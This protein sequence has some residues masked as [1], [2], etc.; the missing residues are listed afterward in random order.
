MHY[1]ILS[2]AFA[3][4]SGL[5]V[6]TAH[7]VRERRRQ[8]E[9]LKALVSAEEPRAIGQAQRD[10]LS[11]FFIT[12]LPRITQ[13]LVPRQEGDSRTQTP[14]RGL[15]VQ[16]G[17]YQKEHE[18]IFIG[19][20]YVVTCLP[21]VGFVAGWLSHLWDMDQNWIIVTGLFMFAAWNLPMAWLNRRKRARQ[22]VL[23]GALPDALD[24]IMICLEGGLSLP[25]ALCRIASELHTV[26]PELALEMTIV[27][28]YIQ[29]G[30]SAGEAL[31]LFADRCDLDEARSLSSAVLQS[32]RF[33]ASLVSSLRI[34]SDMLRMRR[35]QMAEEKAH[36]AS[37]QVLFPTLLL[38]FPAVFIVLI[39]P[40][41][42]QI[43]EIFDKMNATAAQA[44]TDFPTLP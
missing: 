25:A 6:M 27:E 34:Q 32:E 9:R 16:A 38:I 22:Q 15:L 26:H 5:T 11:E 36:K 14:L 23:R 13:F 28:R 31:R 18:V 8:N 4:V 43:V 19:A 29:M 2:L 35:M 21:A 1:F 17:L 40:A 33:G 10:P 3:A 30:R 37:V 41:G 12:T 44:T 20:R 42:M 39:G 7:L 24:L